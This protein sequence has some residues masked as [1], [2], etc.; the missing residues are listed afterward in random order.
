LDDFKPVAGVMLLLLIARSPRVA[1]V[2]Y[3]GR[4]SERTNNQET[5]PSLDDNASPVG[6]NTQQGLSCW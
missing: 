3:T 5:L 1:V 6:E 4:A 2:V